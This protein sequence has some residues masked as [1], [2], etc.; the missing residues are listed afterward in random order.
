MKK[1]F[2]M[3][4]LFSVLLAFYS[5]VSAATFPAWEQGRFAYV[6]NEKDDTLVVIDLKTEKTLTTLQTGKIPHALVFT[7]EGKGYVN[8]RGSQTLTVIDGNHFKVTNTIKLP[9]TSFQIALSPDHKMLAVGYKDALQV[10]FV[11]TQTD[12]LLATVKIGEEPAGTKTTRMKHP[13]WS[14]DGQFVYIGDNVNRTVVKVDARNFKVAATIPVAATGHH[15]VLHQDGKHLYVAHENNTD[16]GTSVSVI[17]VAT[18]TVLKNIM[19]PLG[20][21]E[22]AKGHHGTFDHSGR[23]FFFCNE[24]G[25]TVTVIDSTDMSVV[26]ML[27]A[28]MGAGHAYFAK[29]GQYAYI[30]PHKDNVVTVVDVAKQEAVQS[31]PA[32]KGKKLGHSGYFSADGRYFYVLNAPDQLLVKIDLQQRATVSSMPVGK[33]PLILVVR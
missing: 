3:A 15:F 32:G 28:G 7:P 8:N 31:I 26:K 4:T 30:V 21:D 12:T 6:T 24:G 11:D 25:T 13:F 5:A 22:K 2:S 20:K 10:S 29:G 19:I 23:Y 33:K 1:N 27:Q 16:G 14:K 18:D 9:A 17:D